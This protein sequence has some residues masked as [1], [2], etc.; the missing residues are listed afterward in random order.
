M[1]TDNVTSILVSHDAEWLVRHPRL[2]AALAAAIRTPVADERFAERVWALVRADEARALAMQQVLRT[3]LGTP[4]WL[5]SLNVI[6]IAVT[7]AA[8]ALALSAVAAAGPLAELAAVGRA[9]VEQPPDSMR[10]V[11]LLASVAALWIGLRLAP[12]ARAFG[13]PWL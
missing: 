13:S 11:T 7:T 1:E 3:R 8:V 5:A 10:L 6:A 9:F 12:V 2:D 4:W